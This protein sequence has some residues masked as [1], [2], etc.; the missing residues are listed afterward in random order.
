MECHRHARRICFG[1][2]CAVGGLAVQGRTFKSRTFRLCAQYRGDRDPIS[3]DRLGRRS[4]HGLQPGLLAAL[5]AQPPAFQSSRTGGHKYFHVA[6]QSNDGHQSV[7]HLALVFVASEPKPTAF[8]FV[9]DGQSGDHLDRFTC[10]GPLSAAILESTRLARG[11]RA[12]PFRS[13]L[14][15]V[16]CNAAK[17]P[18]LLL[19]LSLCDGPG[20]GHRRRATQFAAAHLWHAPEPAFPAFCRRSLRALLSP[21]GASRHPLGLQLRMLAVVLASSPCGRA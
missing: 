5:Q 3:A 18:L 4:H 8:P 11:P 13:K 21:D 12:P 6:L 19:L 1:R 15:S 17:W 20:D 16:G 7:P 10:A 2:S 9:F 14:P